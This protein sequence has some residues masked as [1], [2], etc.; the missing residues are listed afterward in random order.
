MIDRPG[1]KDAYEWRLGSKESALVAAVLMPW[2]VVKKEQAELVILSRQLIGLKPQGK[3]RDAS[4]TESLRQLHG[5]LK[6]LK[7]TNSPESIGQNT[8]LVQ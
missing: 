4:T 5:M 8:Q 6:A 2:L 1:K 7:H 3:R